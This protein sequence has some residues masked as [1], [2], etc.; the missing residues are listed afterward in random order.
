MPKSESVKL[1]K[2]EDDPPEKESPPSAPG[3]SSRGKEAS[4]RDK[5][6]LSVALAARLKKRVTDTRAHLDEENPEHIKRK[7]WKLMR[8]QVYQL[9][10]HPRHSNM[11]FAVCTLIFFMIIVS[12]IFAC[13]ETMP[14]LETPFW[15]QFFWT[16]DI[17]FV[18]FFTLEYI[19]RYW[20]S[21]NRSSFV[22]KP[23]NVIDLAALIPFYIELIVWMFFTS[24]HSNDLFRALQL[25]RV[26]RFIRVGRFSTDM[27]F[28]GEGLFRSVQSFFLMSYMLAVGM[29]LCSVCLFMLERGEWDSKKGCFVRANEVFFTG[30][31]P[32][33]SV[34]MSSWWAI[35]TMTTV[36]F[37][38]VFPLTLGGRI[39]A[40]LTMVLGL[41]SVAIPT[42]V[43]GVE[44]ALAYKQQIQER[45][46]NR[47]RKTLTAR[48][49]DELILHQSMQQFNNL[50]EEF[51]VHLPYVKHL[52][53][54]DLE[55]NVPVDEH[56][57]L[58]PTFTIFKTTVL[59]NL[60][61]LKFFVDA[62]TSGL[63][64]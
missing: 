10:D 54:A 14:A 34:P 1:R 22:W 23:L 29:L 18:T 26:L 32:F 35:T 39:A 6:K 3:S 48:N 61:N 31:S 49:K 44:F 56:P 52:A 50:I 46:A 60:S 21:D 27:Q 62:S 9:L 38:D 51:R 13:A 4:A 15:R 43:L 37:G 25:I 2:D 17:V 45:K 28:I 36:G 7:E 19:I 40:G 8:K 63:V 58:D 11:S 41:L 42:T 64:Y 24:A 16:A 55:L 5:G 33:E 20:A 59:S 53:M 12:T 30:C 47:V 57:A